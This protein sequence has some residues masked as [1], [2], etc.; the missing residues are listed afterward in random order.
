MEEMNEERVCLNYNDF[1][2][3]DHQSLNK[4]INVSG[5]PIK[6]ITKDM[7]FG[8]NNLKELKLINCQIESIEQNA[9]ENLNFLSQLNLCGNPLKMIIKDMFFGLNN[10]KEL[11]LINC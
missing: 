3:L 10:L 9:L 11:K 5:N 7:F 6:I 4:Y 2:N 8:L 1:T